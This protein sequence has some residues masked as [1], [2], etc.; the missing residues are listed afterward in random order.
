VADPAQAP[1]S[2]QRELRRHFQKHGSQ[3]ETPTEADYDGSARGTIRAGRRFNYLDADTSAPRVGYYHGRTER[4][5]AMNAS[6]TRI[7]SH[8]N[9]SESYVRNLPGSDYRR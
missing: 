8:Y 2:S 3:L 5:T 6:E 4:F 9:D 7:L 1:W